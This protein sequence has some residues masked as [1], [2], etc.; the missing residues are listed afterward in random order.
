[1]TKIQQ[2]EDTTSTNHELCMKKEDKGTTSIGNR[3]DKEE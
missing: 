3:F 2:T 1:M